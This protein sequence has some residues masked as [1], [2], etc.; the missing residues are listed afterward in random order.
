MDK[1]MKMVMSNKKIK[2][3]NNKEN[4]NFKAIIK[5][6]YKYLFQRNIIIIYPII[7]RLSIP[8]LEIII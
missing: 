5:I 8:K 2:I 6:K 4:C 3:R 1:D 7:T